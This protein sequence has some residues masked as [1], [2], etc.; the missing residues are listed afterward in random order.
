[1]DYALLT[2]GSAFTVGVA[3]EHD[4]VSARVMAATEC[5]H[6]MAAT[7]KYCSD[8]TIVPDPKHVMVVITDINIEAATSEPVYVSYDLPEPRHV[9]SELPESS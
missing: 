3:E 1:M 4:T 5:T 7:T 6:K 2:V 8:T 9:S